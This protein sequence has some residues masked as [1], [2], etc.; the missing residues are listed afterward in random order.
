MRSAFSIGELVRVRKNSAGI[1]EITRILPVTEDGAHFY[2]IR[3][4]QG[5]EIVVRQHEIGSA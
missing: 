1:C 5:S 3:N 4:Q 2:V